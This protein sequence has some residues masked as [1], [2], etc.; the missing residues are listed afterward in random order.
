MEDSLDMRLLEDNAIRARM[1]ELDRQKQMS[2]EEKAE[3]SR[4]HHVYYVV[5]ADIRNY[6]KTY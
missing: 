1:D 4:L 2:E 6:W 5:N 3:Y